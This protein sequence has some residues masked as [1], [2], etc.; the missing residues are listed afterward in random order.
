MRWDGVFIR[1]QLYIKNYRQ[2]W[3]SW[4]EERWSPLELVV[5]RQMVILKN[6]HTNGMSQTEQVTFRSM[7]VYTYT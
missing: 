3:E 1:L 5:Q 6:M 4:D 2:L 7:Y